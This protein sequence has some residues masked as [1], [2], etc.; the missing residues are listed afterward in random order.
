MH[1]AG[2]EKSLKILTM[3]CPN[4]MKNPNVSDEAKKEPKKK[5]EAME[6]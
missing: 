4:A 5:L 3:S 1:A 6:Q 2:Y